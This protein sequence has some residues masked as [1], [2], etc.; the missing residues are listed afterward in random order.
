MKDYKSKQSEQIDCNDLDDL[1]TGKRH[2]K[3]FFA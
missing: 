2:A 3:Y 1:L